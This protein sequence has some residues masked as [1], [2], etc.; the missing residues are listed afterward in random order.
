MLLSQPKGQGDKINVLSSREVSRETVRKMTELLNI[1][2][3]QTALVWEDR[4][5]NLKQLEKKI[6]SV[7]GTDIIIFP[8]MFTT[9]FSMNSVAL[10]E[11]MDGST[12][13]WME[14]MA[15]ERNAVVTGSFICGEG[16]KFY[17]R[18][19]WMQP[20]GKFQTYDK[21][22]LFRM[23]NEHEH[24]APG[25]KRLVVEYK[26]WKINPL[27]CYDLRF[28]VWCRQ[29][30]GESP[31]DLQIF[32][33]NWPERRAFPWKSL[34]VA[35]AIENQCYVAGL[36]RVGKDGHDVSHS[37]DSIVLSPKGEA[38]TRLPASGETVETITIEKAPLTE[39]RS[40]FPV[41]RDADPYSI[42]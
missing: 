11:S 28:P 12:V 36:N 34:L 39:F 20:D 3:V 25:T 15:R 29:K 37:G 33:A 23:G 10:A 27:I 38:L 9:G 21:R 32:V 16:G 19:V 17:N 40:Q 31:F 22:H 4:E 5:A 30:S 8:E 41:N 2:L 7:S 6:Q 26:G 42:G 1:S 18:L 24:Y 14:K 13:K 35:R